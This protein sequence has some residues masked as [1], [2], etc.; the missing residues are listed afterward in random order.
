MNITT[1][2]CSIIVGKLNT[3]LV[4]LSVTELVVFEINDF[5]ISPIS[6]ENASDAKK[7]GKI[8]FK[9]VTISNCWDDLKILNDW[10]ITIGVKNHMN[11]RIITIKENTIK[12]AEKFFD[13]VHL[14]KKSYTGE[15]IN[16][17][18][19]PHIIDIKIGFIMRKDKI[20][21]NK[22]I[23]KVVA[24]LTYSSSNLTILIPFN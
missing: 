11:K 1:V 3:N 12:D 22:K 15:K 10:L 17:K 24:F 13:L 8:F 4:R 16:A 23:P 5:I 19:I 20:I 21:N 9:G 18:R 7:E 2:N 14:T 6:F